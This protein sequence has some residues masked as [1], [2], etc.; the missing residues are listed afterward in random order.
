MDHATHRPAGA[1]AADPV[2]ALYLDHGDMVRRAITAGLRPEDRGT[3]LVDD[4]SQE[5]WLAVVQ[6]VAA[7]RTIRS[8]GLLRTI[9]RHRVTDHYRLAHT[10]RSA[11]ADWS[12]TV[13]ARRLP[14]APA[15]EDR[16]L[17]LVE[18]VAELRDLRAANARLASPRSA[19]AA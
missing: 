17:S 9:A 2:T 16:A 6:Y 12:D 10:R 5:V 1:T 4:L 15:A 13:A 19:V 7:G 14:V 11:P 18:A 3:D 8:G